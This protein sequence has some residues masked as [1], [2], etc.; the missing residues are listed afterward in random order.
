MTKK[1]HG[2][3]ALVVTPNGKDCSDLLFLDI[4]ILVS[5]TYSL[6]CSYKECAA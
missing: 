6:L 1:I 3:Q 5:V 2:H 4:S